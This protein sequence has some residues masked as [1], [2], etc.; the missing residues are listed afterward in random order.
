MLGT[1]TVIEERL[2][3]TTLAVLAHGAHR[4]L[5]VGLGVVTRRSPKVTV[6][7][8]CREPK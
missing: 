4:W 6:E 7:L 5:P 8:P 1:R 3:E 2:H